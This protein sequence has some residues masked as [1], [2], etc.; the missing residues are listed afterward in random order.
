MKNA[1]CKLLKL[2]LDFA[3]C[4]F[5]FTMIYSIYSIRLSLLTILEE[6]LIYILVP[7]IAYQFYC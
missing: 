4:N 3:I 7:W 2:I 6:I 1:N 5:Q